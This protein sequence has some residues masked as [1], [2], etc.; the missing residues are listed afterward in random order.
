M[1]WEG[2]DAWITGH[3]GQDQYGS[4]WYTAGAELKCDLCVN[5]I[6]Y[7]EKYLWD[8]YNELSIC[9]DCAYSSEYDPDDD[10]DSEV[11]WG[12]DE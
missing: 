1:G 9:R 4:G 5:A 3:Y 8:E 11:K 7:M 6:K 10:K 2:L 12:I